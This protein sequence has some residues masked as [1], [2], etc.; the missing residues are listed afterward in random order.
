MTKQYTYDLRQY[1]LRS[2]VLLEAI[3]QVC[4]KHNLRYYIIAGTLLG[5][6]RH[7]GFIP[8]DDDIDI[9]MSRADYDQLM[10]H[11]DEWV[12]KPFR[13]VT[14][15]IEAGYPKYFAK[16]ED[17]STTLV[18]NFGL[19]YVGGIYMDIFPLDAVPNNKLLRYWHFYKFHF[20]RK[21]LYYSYRDPYKH[22]HGLNSWAVKAFQ[23]FFSREGL[24]KASQKVLREYNDKA[25]CD[26]VMTH[27][28]GPRA[29]RNAIFGE[30]RDYEFEGKMFCGPAVSEGFLGVL[31]GPT[32]MQLPPE[33]KRRSHYHQYCDLEHGCDGVDLATLANRKS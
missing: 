32:Y 17:R 22:G 10:A 7:R 27:D 18:E 6:V 16:L 23:H 19:G 13:I 3:D 26:Y 28:D 31:Y 33:D 4:S 14:H 5:A 15:E 24:H 20:L 25:A 9:A 30:P 2:V 21:M 11:A 29:Y 8:W 1:Q 12:P